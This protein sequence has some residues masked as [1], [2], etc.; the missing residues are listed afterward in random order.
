MYW[1]ANNVNSC[2]DNKTE[3]ETDI[4]L[5]IWRSFLQMVP[6]DASI[7]DLATGNG[8]VP[9]KLLTLNKNLNLTG[10]DRANISPIDYVHYE[11]KLRDVSFIGNTDICALPFSD[12]QFDGVTSQFG[13]EYADKNFAVS[14]FIRV[15]KPNGY[16]QLIIH[17]V[18]SDIVQPAKSTMNELTL[19][20]ESQGLVCKLEAFVKNHV[21][22]S[23]LESFYKQFIFKHKG[24][25]TERITGQ[26][27]DFAEGILKQSKNGYAL[28][29]FLS[30][31]TS[32]SN[33]VHGEL[34]RLRQ[35]TSAA[36][37]QDEAQLICQQL[38]PLCS[39]VNLTP[40]LIDNHAHDPIIAWSISGKK[41]Q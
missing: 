15:L 1:Q 19:V 24:Q 32:L 35:L 17:H 5:H 33:R 8:S 13:F 11:K 26:I 4:F 38:T 29:P 12:H 21:S 40:I 30:S 10:V 25:L 3:S 22:S 28:S 7:L 16:F 41:S 20:L 9:L 34:E 14:E 27:L 2:I 18:N 6:N 36:L 31:I 39:R 23:D 37:S